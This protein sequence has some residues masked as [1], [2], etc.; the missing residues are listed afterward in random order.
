MHATPIVRVSVLTLALAMTVGTGTVAARPDTGGRDIQDFA[1]ADFYQTVAECL[2][3]S[4]AVRFFA[5]DNL[6]TPIGS[7]QP[8]SWSDTDIHLN[9]IDTCVEPERVVLSLECF[10]AVEDPDMDRFEQASL[11][12]DVPCD[13]GVSAAINLEWTGNDDA[14]VRIDHS[15]SDGYFRQERFETASVSGTLVFDP[16]PGWTEDEL[17]FTGADVTGAAIGTANEISLPR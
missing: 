11:H 10:A 3:A 8:S 17:A 4:A 7:G 9:L 5:G 6:Q 16:I 14:T 1:T 2:D 12:V 15:L 13:L